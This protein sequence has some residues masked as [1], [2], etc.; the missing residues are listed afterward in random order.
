MGR[1]LN[2]MTRLVGGRGVLVAQCQQHLTNDELAAPYYSQAGHHRATLRP[3]ARD[4]G[5]A[6]QDGGGR[7]TRFAQGHSVQL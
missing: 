1:D 3:M 4:A 7:A 2:P 5:C 6:G